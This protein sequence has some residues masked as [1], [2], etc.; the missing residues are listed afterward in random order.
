MRR[1]R[2]KTYELLTPYFA[3]WTPRATAFEPFAHFLSEASTTLERMLI[4]DSAQTGESFW[5]MVES[6]NLSDAAARK[7]TR[8]VRKRSQTFLEEVDEWLE[9]NER[10]IAKGRPSEDRGELA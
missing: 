4:P 1:T 2:R 10:P 8:F 7:F 3:V 6:T 5:R 9:A